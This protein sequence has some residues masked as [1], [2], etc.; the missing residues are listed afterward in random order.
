MPATRKPT[1][2]DAYRTQLEQLADWDDYLR[3]ESRLPGP[4]AN[5]E[6]LEAGDRG[7]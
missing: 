2:I 6:L 3:Q 4:R 5:L 1:P 7:R